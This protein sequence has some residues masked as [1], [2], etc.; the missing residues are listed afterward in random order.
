MKI[1]LAVDDS[2]FSEAATKKL[3]AEIRPQDSEV[4][5]LEVVEPLVSMIPPEASPDDVPVAVTEQH[6][7]LE[8]ANET[9][10]HAAEALR[11]AGFAKVQARVIEGSIRP[12]ILSAAEE[13]HADLIVLG[14]H[15]RT[16]LK[17]FLLGSVAESI[18]EEAH[19]S[20]LIVRSAA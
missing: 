9:V 15:G 3:A 5:V 12:G 10:T 7:Q 11:N 4:L 8:Q 17:K 1:L 16:G 19:C 2:E 13:W 20:T 14:T 6:E 18:A